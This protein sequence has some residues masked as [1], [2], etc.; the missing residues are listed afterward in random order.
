MQ[1]HN[2]NKTYYHIVDN[3]RH[4][5]Q[6]DIFNDIKYKCIMDF[7]KEHLKQILEEQIGGK[8]D[9]KVKRGYDRLEKIKKILYDT[10]TQ[11]PQIISYV[12]N[13]NTDADIKIATEYMQTGAGDK[14]DIIQL[15]K[16]I[17]HVYNVI[18]SNR[19]N[20]ENA[21]VFAETI[22]KNYITIQNKLISNNLIGGNTNNTNI[23]NQQQKEENIYHAPDILNRY[24][25]YIKNAINVLNKRQNNIFDGVD[26]LA[27]VKS[28]ILVI[29]MC[30]GSVNDGY[31]VTEKHKKLNNKHITDMIYKYIMD[32]LRVVTN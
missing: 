12:L 25:S 32:L 8:I 11:H 21:T 13:Q 19:Y 7:G 28:E 30:D 1:H 29:L 22:K 6:N 24:I 15:I 23:Y 2:I 26:E 27:I 3:I 10:T 31:T 5:M 17:K 9:E 20:E 4:I 14:N 18:H 16:E